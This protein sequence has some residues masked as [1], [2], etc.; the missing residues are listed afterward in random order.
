MAEGTNLFDIIG[1]TRAMRRL[2][3][4]PIPDELIR[5]ILEAGVCAQRWQPS[6]LALSG[7]QRP[8]HQGEGATL[9]QARSRRGGGAALSH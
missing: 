2:K 7:R 6:T 9:L 5:K 1:T 4:D 8:R 3:P